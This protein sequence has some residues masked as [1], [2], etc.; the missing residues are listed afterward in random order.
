[1]AFFPKASQARE[2]GQGNR[3]I[4]EEV[5]LLELA[6]TDAIANGNL[7]V[8]YGGS[9]SDSSQSTITVNGVT[10]TASPMTMENSTGQSYYNVW[11]G[12]TTNAARTEQMNE[13]ISYFEG[14][15]YT[16]SRKSSNSSTFY[17]S[18]SW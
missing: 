18:I 1:M 9:L 3:I 7:T 16:I 5:M 10:V 2:R 6:I 11:K 12:N 15:G 8:D 4:I 14:K 13:V 17:W